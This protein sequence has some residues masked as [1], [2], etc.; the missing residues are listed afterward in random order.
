MGFTTNQLNIMNAVKVP[1]H[2][3]K[4]HIPA[5]TFV[6][7]FQTK[8]TTTLNA[9]KGGDK[10]KKRRRRKKPL[11]ETPEA[12]STPTT[13]PPSPSTIIEKVDDVA[14][15]E[16]IEKDTKIETPSSSSPFSFNKDEAIALGK[17]SSNNMILF[18]FDHIVQ[19]CSANILWY[20]LHCNL[21]KHITK[22]ESRMLKT[23]M[24]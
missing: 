17:E 1:I 12:V 6:S 18:C 5:T 7:P 4:Y 16:S 11:P 13:A 8:T 22:K 19:V 14:Q 21:R 10:G 15:I 9:A 24:I 2:Q 3:Q 20:I 23:M